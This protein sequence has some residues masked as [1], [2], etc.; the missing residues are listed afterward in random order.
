MPTT[1][2]EFAPKPLPLVNVVF[3]TDDEDEEPGVVT[4]HDAPMA[5][6][7]RHNLPKRAGKVLLTALSPA[8]TGAQFG[9][10]SSGTLLTGVALAGGGAVAATPIGLAAA[11]ATAMIVSSTLSVVSAVKTNAHITGLV[12]LYEARQSFKGKENCAEIVGDGVEDVTNYAQTAHEI[13]ANQVLSYVINKK[14]NKLV[15]KFASSIPGGGLL[16]GGYGIGN[17][18]YKALSGTLGVNRTNAAKWLASH[19]LNCNCKLTNGIIA[20]LFSEKEMQSFAALRYETLWET[21]SPKLKSN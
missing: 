10:G 8:I 19:F 6:E 11:G 12:K 16:T 13:V 18:A 5:A 14:R 7:N 15:K 20:E 1:I 9:T 2:P 21:L 4:F 3:H 17:K